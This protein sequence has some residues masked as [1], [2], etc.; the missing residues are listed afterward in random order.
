MSKKIKEAEKRLAYEDWKRRR[1]ER[2][3]EAEDKL[4]QNRNLSPE[5][6][7]NR[8]K[9]PEIAKFVDELRTVFPEAK[10][11]KI[12]PLPQANHG[13]VEQVSTDDQK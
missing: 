3:K 1:D 8:E 4:N 6:R 5:A 10:V 11:V 7:R 12:T 2:D 13:S 9:Y